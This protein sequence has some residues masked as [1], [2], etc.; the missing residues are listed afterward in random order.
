MPRKDGGMRTARRGGFRHLTERG[1]DRRFKSCAV[2]QNRGVY[3]WIAPAGEDASE[4]DHKQGV[5]VLL[6]RWE[7][8]NRGLKVEITEKEKAAIE[9]GLNKSGKT[10]VSL[11]V[12]NGKIEVVLIEKK[13][14][15]K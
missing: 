10:E 13:K 12:V 2:H 15:N 14:I 4:P 11:R 9:Y 8:G 5:P 3:L 1:R 6:K 7:G